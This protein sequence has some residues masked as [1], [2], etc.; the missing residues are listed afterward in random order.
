MKKFLLILFLCSSTLIVQA[1]ERFSSIDDL[2]EVL[3]ASISGSA[4][5]ARDSSLITSIFLPEAKLMPIARNKEGKV[6]AKVLSVEQYISRLVKY[7]LNEG[8]FE[9]EIH[10]ET[11]RY[12]N[13]AQVFSTYA[14]YKNKEDKAPYQRGINSLQLMFDGHRWWVMNI[15]WDAEST[16]NPIPKQYLKK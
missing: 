1:Q 7:T 12:G 15:T 14:S 13:I 11:Q 10:R 4:G 8:F 3:Y 5:E 2:M 9:R 16:G 6:I